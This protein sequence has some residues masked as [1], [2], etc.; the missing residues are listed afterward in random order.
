MQI[1]LLK[2]KLHRACVTG[3][4]VHYE[5]SLT[6]DA[7]LMDLVGLCPYERILCGNMA[8]GERFETYAIPGRRG[9]GEIVL[10]GAT[11]LLGKPGDLLTIMSYAV[12]KAKQAGKWV[13]RVIVLGKKNKVIT[14][15]GTKK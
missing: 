1:H 11:A 3:G 5:G 9:S 8:N 14:K 10:N 13:P 7:D 4:S 15:R 12:V 6:I 2:S